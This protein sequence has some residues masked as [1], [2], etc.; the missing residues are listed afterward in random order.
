MV[1]VK[2][3]TGRFIQKINLL[4]HTLITTYPDDPSIGQQFPGKF[5]GFIS[6]RG[7]FVSPHTTMPKTFIIGDPDECVWEWYGT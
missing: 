2:K 7:V 5:S 4:K 1:E 6:S 3:T